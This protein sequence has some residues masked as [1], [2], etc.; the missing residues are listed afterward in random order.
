MSARTRTARKSTANTFSYAELPSSG[1]EDEDEE[2]SESGRGGGGRNSKAKGPTKRAKG[3][4]KA[5]EVDD[6]DEGDE[7]VQPRKKARGPAKGKQRKHNK[8]KGQLEVFKTLPVEM[9]TEIFSHLYPNDLLALSMVNKEYRALLT[10]KSS[11][12]LWK[13]ARDKLKLPDVVTDHFSEVQYASLV[14]GRNC[15]ICGISKY[16]SLDGRLRLRACKSCRTQ[17]FVKLSSIERTHPDVLAKLHPRA[18]DVVIKS[19]GYVLLSDLYRATVILK[20]LED[21]DE[22]DDIAEGNV[23]APLAPSPTPSSGRRRSSRARSF[24]TWTP[25]QDDMSDNEDDSASPYTRRVNEYIVA[26]SALFKEINEHARNIAVAYKTVQDHVRMV[27]WEVHR[28]RYNRI[29]FKQLVDKILD[30]DLGY[31]AY[32]FYGSWSRSKLVTSPDPLTDEEWVRIKPELLALLDR[33]KERLTKQVARFKAKSEQRKRKESLR[34]LYE[35]L[36]ASLPK[37]ARPFVPLFLDFLLLPSVKALW[38]DNDDVEAMKQAWTMA[39]EDIKDEVD[40]F[41]LDLVAHAR[42]LVLEAT[43]DPDDL[44]HG[45]DADD[46]DGDLDKFF[47]LAA[48]FVCCDFGYCRR[49]SKREY[50]WPPR[51]QISKAHRKFRNIGPLVDVL[52]HL[53]KYHDDDYIPYSGHG[54]NA[55]PQF[56]ISLPLEVACAA[57]ALLE[58]NQLDPSTAGVAE[59]DRAGKSVRKYVWENHSSTWRNYSGESAWF[60]LLYAVKKEG[61]RLARLKPPVYLDPPVVVMNPARNGVAPAASD[62]DQQEQLDEAD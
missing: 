38:G 18:Q 5:V 24:K 9:I 6:G 45:L 62:D 23:A 29:R 58:V 49:P 61:Q 8:A 54:V 53:R 56:H 10:A 47:S 12:R 37:P 7:D 43:T 16:V 3:K 1:D 27:G 22:D 60:D 52:K 34:P 17:H 31:G 26:R 30:L 33:D 59:L 4:A 28:Q 2:L 36:C 40:Q 11:A 55:Q 46:L 50:T 19:G 25:R 42:S 14:F 57:S 20:D 35:K 48:S 41:R 44:S 32:D 39:L 13:A 21:Q 15:Q 51:H